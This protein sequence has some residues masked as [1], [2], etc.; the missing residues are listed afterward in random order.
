MRCLINLVTHP[1]AV[2]MC[3][4]WLL[5][6][7]QCYPEITFDYWVRSDAAAWL[8][9]ALPTQNI[10]IYPHQQ[11]AMGPYDLVLHACTHQAVIKQCYDWGIKNRV[12]WWNKKVYWRYCS[13]YVWPIKAAQSSSMLAQYAPLF[14]TFQLG[15]PL[16]FQSVNELWAKTL[17]P[18][19]QLKIVLDCSASATGACWPLSAWQALYAQ[20]RHAG[21]SV[22]VLQGWHES[23]VKYS[24]TQVWQTS[25]LC[26]SAGGVLSMAAALNYPVIGLMSWQDH[27]QWY[28]FGAQVS[29]IA[30]KTLDGISVAQVFN[31]VVNDYQRLAQLQYPEALP[32]E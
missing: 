7:K 23:M 18:T 11:Q 17:L 22:Y 12:G 29:M 30:S 24:L 13:R 32:Y 19:T 14:S 1:S 31:Q 2:V 8:K 5:Q 15:E 6:L 28:P 21:Y 20:L 9:S 27:P 4:P 16:S 26:V 10:W 3:W 25:V